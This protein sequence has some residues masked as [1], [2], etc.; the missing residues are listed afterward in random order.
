MIDVLLGASYR[1]YHLNSGNT[2][3]YEP[4][5]PIN[6]SEYGSYIQLQ[7]HLFNNVLKLTASGRYDKNENF[8]GR[9]TPRATATIKVAKDNNFRLSYQQAYRF[10][11]NQDQYINLFTPGSVLIGC[12]PVFNTLYQFDQYPVYTATSVDSFRTTQL[13]L[14]YCAKQLFLKQGRKQ[15]NRMRLVIA[16]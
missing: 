16:V 4:N 6:I 13:I 10:P 5:G 7:K 11:N 12:L 1:I 3:F 8:K 15:W 2:I 14:K 9:F